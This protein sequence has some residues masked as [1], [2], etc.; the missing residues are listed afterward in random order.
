MSFAEK[1]EDQ[2]K[3][4]ERTS[5]WAGRLK[6]IKDKTGRNIKDICEKY[7]LD[8]TQLSHIMAGRRGARWET[9]N[10]VE[11]ALAAEEAAASVGNLAD[12]PQEKPGDE[13][14]GI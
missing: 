5:A 12:K 14:P 9:I 6:T 2:A 8:N 13:K 7:G 4:L 10:A 11:A 3:R 1:V